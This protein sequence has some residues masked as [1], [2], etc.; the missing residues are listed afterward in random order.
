MLYVSFAISPA[1][2]MLY[3]LFT[4]PDRAARDAVWDTF[5]VHGVWG[6]AFSEAG[7]KEMREMQATLEATYF[8]E[9]DRT[10]AAKK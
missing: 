7:A 5:V 4:A 10:K 8:L 2:W 3:R 1:V 6:M 9:Q